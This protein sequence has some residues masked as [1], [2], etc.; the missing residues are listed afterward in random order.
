[1][2]DDSLPGLGGLHG[3]SDADLVAGIAG[4]SS[5]AAV[6]E[7]R[8]LAAVAE[9]AR[10]AGERGVHPRGACDDTDAAAAELACALTI[11]HGRALG[12][13][14]TATTLRDRLPRVGARFLAGEVS[15]GVVWRIVWHTGL[16]RD[17]AVWAA[18]DAELS[19]RASAWGALSAAKLETAIEFWIDKYDP[20]AVRRV[21]ARVRGRSFTIGKR[22]D[23]AGTAAVYGSLSIA[24]AAVWEER[25]AVMLA[26]VC[27]DDPRTLG[28]R[29]ADAVGAVGAG[30]FVLA[31][32]CDNPDCA[33]RGVDDGRAS[34]VSIHVF[35]EQGSVDASLDP[36][37]HGQERPTTGL[38][39]TQPQPAS[40]TEPASESAPVGAKPR[41]AGVIPAMR[42]AIVPAALLADLIAR[43]AK[44]RFVGGLEDV[45]G[46]EGYRPSA[47]L[48]RFVRARDLTCRMPGCDRPAVH[49]DIDHTR[50]YPYGPT[51][52]SNMKCYCRF[53]HLLKTFWPGWTDRQEPDGSVHITTPTGRTYTTKPFSALL[54]PRWN[55]T[56]APLEDAPSAPA[57]SAERG[58]KMPTR[59][60]SREQAREYRITRERHLNAI[61][62][63]LDLAAAQAA[64]AERAA[65]RAQK[66]NRKQTPDH[67]PIDYL[68]LSLSRPPGYQPDYGD[69]PPPF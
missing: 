29:R 43:G 68:G 58:R 52:P 46:V 69:D 17:A 11:S 12:L 47:A 45:A 65:K 40:E 4:W 44:V 2:F 5:A 34:S 27:E 15:A 53:H 60:R 6:A 57:L 26:G 23:Q 67:D 21:R 19:Q 63:E 66:Q 36:G 56:T 51:H 35:A 14:D 54:F 20:D 49:G 18:L 7:A 16:V 64:A 55:T 25:L 39:W 32:G 28:Q 3:L 42:N 10:R 59:I 30:S 37:L 38:P 8:K 9:W 1:M 41:T 31:C 62:R 33:A 22:D 48:D 24:D 61:Q 13:M 50:P